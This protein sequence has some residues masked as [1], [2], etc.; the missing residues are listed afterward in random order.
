VQGPVTAPTEWDQIRTGFTTEAFVGAVMEVVTERPF[1]A[2]DETVRLGAVVL[3]PVRCPPL[4]ERKPLLT[5]HVVAISS[6][7]VNATH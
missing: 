5:G 6:T 4:S 1:G 2:A 7:T 3:D